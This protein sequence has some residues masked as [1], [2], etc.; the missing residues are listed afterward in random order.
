M[1]IVNHFSHVVIMCFF[2][3]FLNVPGYKSIVIHVIQRW[4]CIV[5]HNEWCANNPDIKNKMAYAR[6]YC[7][8]P[9]LHHT[10]QLL[11]LFIYFFTLNFILSARVG[12]T[13]TRFICLIL[14]FARVFIF[15]VYFSI[16]SMYL[17]R[18]QT[19]LPFCSTC[20]GTEAQPSICWYYFWNNTQSYLDL[21]FFSW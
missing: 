18:T 16:S 7:F 6:R 1:Y 11:L 9:I 17:R 13:V 10:W 3:P 8:L 5:N 14:I 2:F 15:T 20:V 21:R 19:R 12:F 4:R